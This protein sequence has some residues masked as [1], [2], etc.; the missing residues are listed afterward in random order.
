M[1]LCRVA[2]V[3]G[4]SSSCH[5][6]VTI[7]A[8]AMVLSVFGTLNAASSCR[9]DSIA[10]LFRNMLSH[11]QTL[12]KGGP[13]TLVLKGMTP[14]F[15]SSNTSSLGLG[16]L[17]REDAQKGCPLSSR[18]TRLPLDFR[19]NQASGSPARRP[20]CTLVFVNITGSRGTCPP[21][22]PPTVPRIPFHG[23]A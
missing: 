14:T 21:V 9:F 5:N 20:I 8:A 10:F 11:S 17:L 18:S 12:P 6:R 22:P 1:D 2:A 4:G 16:S 15:L 19:R 3:N 7:G 13:P 23:A